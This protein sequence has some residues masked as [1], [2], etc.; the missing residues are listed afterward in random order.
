MKALLLSFVIFA[1][2]SCG[3]NSPLAAHIKDHLS[4]GDNSGTSQNAGLTIEVVEDLPTT[5]V[6]DATYGGDDGAQAFIPFMHLAFIAGERDVTV[7]MV[8]FQ[9]SGISSYLDVSGL[10]LYEGN[11]VG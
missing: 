6:A 5:I 4:D 10:Y 7:Y 9:H 2:T 1:L 3:P 8:H 11:G